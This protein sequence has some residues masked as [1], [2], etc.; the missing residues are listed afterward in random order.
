MLFDPGQRRALAVD[1]ATEGENHAEIHL[2]RDVGSLRYAGS[3]LAFFFA[4]IA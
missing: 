3:G 4:E 1:A 2:C